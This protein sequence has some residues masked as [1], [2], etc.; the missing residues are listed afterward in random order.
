MCQ[1]THSKQVLNSRVDK[2]SFQTLT[3][4]VVVED[5]S[6]LNEEIIGE[7]MSRICQQAVERI[8]RTRK[9]AGT[10]FA[11]LLYR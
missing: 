1:I 2:I 7:M 9:V 11:A 3:I 8:D 5:D 4:S 10:A 6:L